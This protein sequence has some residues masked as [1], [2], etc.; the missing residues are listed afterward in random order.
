[1]IFFRLSVE[2]LDKSKL[3]ILFFITKLLKNNIIT[4]ND[5]KCAGVKCNSSQGCFCCEILFFCFVHKF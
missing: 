3:K 5:V 2:S 1:M 4:Q